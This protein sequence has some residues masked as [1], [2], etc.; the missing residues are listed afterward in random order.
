MSMENKKV[1]HIDRNNYYGGDMTSVSPIERLFEMFNTEKTSKDY[2]GSKD[3]NVDLV[4]KFL[5]ASGM[6]LYLCNVKVIW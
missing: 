4:S 5:M 2:H 1:L 3:W 6:F